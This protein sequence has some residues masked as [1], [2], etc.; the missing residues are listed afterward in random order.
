MRALIVED[1]ADLG[2]L[3]S[4]QLRQDGFVVDR[5]GT[6]AAGSLLSA[7][8]AYELLLIDWNLPDGSGLDV[9]A[10]YRAA[11]HSGSAVLITARSTLEDLVMGLEAGADDI[12]TKPFD[13]R[14]LKARIHALFRRA[15][16]WAREVYRTGDLIVDCDRRIAAVR[17]EIMPLTTKEWQVL[18]LLVRQPGRVVPRAELVTHAWVEIGGAWLRGYH[19]RLAGGGIPV[20]VAQNSRSE[21]GRAHV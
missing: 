18:R 1:D 12:L 21:I 6:R 8:T 7:T 4:R 2:S 14:E 15:H 17:D 5:A 3:L 10:S 9:L 11:G 20:V 19:P 16:P 13:W